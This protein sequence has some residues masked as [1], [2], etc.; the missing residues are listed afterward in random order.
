MKLKGTP[1]RRIISEEWRQFLPNSLPSAFSFCPVFNLR[2]PHRLPLHVRGNFSSATFQR[3]DVI[4]DVAL[5]PLR[6]TCP[7]HEVRSCRRAT[8][9]PAVATSYG[10]RRSLRNRRL[11]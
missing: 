5:P 3:H 7:P 6:I 11:P 4:H 1:L 8:L 10:D 2:F 9:D